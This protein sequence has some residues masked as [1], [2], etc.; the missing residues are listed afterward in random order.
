MGDATDTL[1]LSSDV[2]STEIPPLLRKMIDNARNGVDES[3]E[4]TSFSGGNVGAVPISFL[5]PAAVGIGSVGVN[6]PLVA[7]VVGEFAVFPQRD[8]RTAE[9]INIAYFTEPDPY[10]TTDMLNS[11]LDPQI[12]I[13][14]I[15]NNT[16]H[17]RTI[18]SMEGLRP[19]ST[20]PLHS[21]T[22]GFTRADIEPSPRDAARAP[23]P[24]IETPALE[25]AAYPLE[26]SAKGT[27]TATVVGVHQ[28]SHN[29]TDR[30]LDPSKKDAT[31]QPAV[32]PAAE[33]PKETAAS[34][35][36]STV[37]AAAAPIKDKV[38]AST[39]SATEPL[40]AKIAAVAPPIK[41]K[42]ATTAAPIKEQLDHLQ[43]AA[44]HLISTYEPAE[45]DDGIATDLKRALPKAAEFL[46]TV[47]PIISIAMMA[48]AALVG[49]AIGHMRWSWLWV[50]I[51]G[52]SLVLYITDLRSTMS[53]AVQY[54]S[55]RN[56]AILSLGNK[57]ETAEWI[58]F[59]IQQLWPIID[60][61]LMATVID[62]LEDQFV[63]QAPAFITRIHIAD[64][65]LGPHAPSVKSM[66]VY[67]GASGEDGIL[68]DVALAMEPK[69]S[70]L[71]QKTRLNT[72]LMLVISLGSNKLGSIS[73]PI[74]AEVASFSAK[75]RLQFQL[76]SKA[77][78]VST[79]KFTLLED[80]KFEFSVNP[81]KAG[82]IMNMPLLSN[83]I[84]ST[85]EKVVH[86]M[87]VSPKVMAVELDRILD[88]TLVRSLGILKVTFRQATNLRSADLGGSADP[89]ASLSFGNSTNLLCRTRILPSDRNPVWNESHY[90]LLTED[91]VK[92]GIPIVAKVWDHDRMRPDDEL[93][94][95]AFKI[96]DLVDQD[97]VLFD[98]WKTLVGKAEGDDG[99]TV[100]RGRANVQIGFFPKLGKE[101][102][103][104]D[105]ETF[106]GGILQMWVHECADLIL[107][108]KD[109]EG[110]YVSP[111]V[112]VY[113]NDVLKFSTRI[114]HVNPSPVWNASTEIFI[115][116]WR[117]TRVRIVVKDGRL[118]EHDPVIGILVIKLG[119]VLSKDDDMMYMSWNPLT[120]GI[121]FGKIRT[122]FMFQPV[123]MQEP[124]HLKGFD[125]GELEFRDLKVTNLGRILKDNSKLPN[126]YIRI[127][128]PVSDPHKKSTKTTSKPTDDPDW[129]EENPI[130]F[131]ITHRYQTAFRIEVRRRGMLG[132]ADSTIAVGRM[133][134]Q[135]LEDN[136]EKDVVLE[137]KRWVKKEKSLAQSGEPVDGGHSTEITRPGDVDPSVDS[138][139][140]NET[141]SRMAG[142]EVQAI[143]DEHL[144]IPDAPKP[145]DKHTTTNPLRKA[146]SFTSD[147]SDTTEE[148]NDESDTESVASDVSEGDTETISF[149]TEDEKPTLQFKAVF[150]GGLRWISQSLEGEEM[151]LASFAEEDEKSSHHGG[152]DGD[153][154]ATD[155]PMKS[156]IEAHEKETKHMHG[157][158]KR[159]FTLSG[160]DPAAANV[161]A[162][163]KSKHKSK[164]RKN[165]KK[166]GSAGLVSGVG[167]PEG[168]DGDT[169]RLPGTKGTRTMK[170]GKDVL[171]GGVKNLPL[172]KK[173]GPEDVIRG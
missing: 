32:N 13:D 147:K 64:F 50:L 154:E 170:W 9:L 8:I 144:D 113:L 89:Y 90:I 44:H 140:K 52:I 4:T 41:E 23:V 45:R 104:E 123:K 158:G 60:P 54:E 102:R 99:Q 103:K 1:A 26:G 111:Y 139:A 132:L 107:R 126:V 162:A 42:L 95:F 91:D 47:N 135:D 156:A 24:P 85:I 98:G 160:T 6:D 112:H 109:R 62:Q 51:L 101:D 105:S 83:F 106:H 168:G 10:P 80:P 133:F 27:P 87:L 68:M 146:L 149:T 115:R 143:D 19:D 81:L 159:L 100:K 71:A 161:N 7:G 164:D 15:G 171:L 157:I 163:V 69:P 5:D 11:S 120:G 77:P 151:E 30:S 22:E 75:M 14:P 169:K 122:T 92:R 34:R 127:R 155:D 66:Q 76:A 56:D 73:V 16:S 116:D 72:H 150:N 108:P 130:K 43:K 124:E 35:I 58:N 88:N 167:D 172:V 96:E 63:A 78:F 121:G 141:S 153:H 2:G 65:E 165:I 86:D 74:L 117:T 40:K 142:G 79:V 28:A 114:K 138:D 25:E 119:D 93:G 148:N 137:L 38:V 94:R 31:G 12:P 17:I 49:W 70:E 97:G 55:K 39:S 173:V 131:R 128:S 53:K 21:G 152:G 20:A 136:K 37:T 48:G 134:L 145:S 3:E 46:M 18:P 84:M 110:L 125:V 67:P 57:A 29:P 33:S 36:Q 166:D 59:F 129:S 118:H 82:N 61:S